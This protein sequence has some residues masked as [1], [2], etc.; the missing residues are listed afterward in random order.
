MIVLYFIS[1]LV[2]YGVVR[3]KRRQALIDGGQAG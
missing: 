1:V 2:S 3:K